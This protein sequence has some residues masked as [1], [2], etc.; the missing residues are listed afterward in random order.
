M[1]GEHSHHHDHD[2]EGRGL[3]ASLGLTLVFAFVE[4]GTGLFA[5]SLALL[6]D[7][8]HM[9]SDTLALALSLF[10]VWIA[11]RP[12]SARHSYGFVRTEIIA[13]FV[14]A[15]ALL[16]VV[17][18]IVIAA[19]RRLQH[20]E[21]VSGG[22][23][24]IVAA[25]G[26]VI[27]GGV[28]YALSRERRTLNTKSAILHVLGDLLGSA[29]AL[30]AGAVIYFTGWFPIDPV[31][32][33]VISG[34]ILYSTVQLLR[35]TLN[36][37]MEGVPSHLDLRTVGRALAEVPG[38]ISVHDLH[39]WTLSSGLLALSA[40]VVVADLA[41]WSDLLKVMQ[42][43]LHDRFDIGHI[44]LQPELMDVSPARGRLVIPI[45]PRA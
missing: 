7:A 36:V 1:G 40:H 37:L 16:A 12:P 15:L 23:V 19:I 4:A 22:A 8:G 31:L 32:S 21:P 33:L 3:W 26:I 43:M 17:T 39:I 41:R 9:L 10:A 20:P 18:V 35:E 2:A 25:L 13:A 45:H 24:I 30:V 29:A 5:H 34:L 27:N 28:V 6:S 44:T 11:R 38:A 14:N 42:G